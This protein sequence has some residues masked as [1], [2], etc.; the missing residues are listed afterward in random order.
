MTD[1]TD[2]TIRRPSVPKDLDDELA[3]AV[4]E[5]VR[6]PADRLT[7]ADR[8]RILLDE[9]EKRGDDLDELQDVEATNAALRDELAEAKAEV[10]ELKAELADSRR[11]LVG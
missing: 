6:V 4:T 2:R 10:E 8:V 1:T 7:F 11:G 3:S 5:H 9:Y